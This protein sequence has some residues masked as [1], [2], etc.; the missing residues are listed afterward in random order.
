MTEQER[1][2][3]MTEAILFSSGEPVEISRIARTLGIL[4]RDVIH[5]I[6]HLQNRYAETNSALQ[7]LHLETSVQIGTKPE[8]ASII[9]TALETKR[10]QPLSNAAMEVLTIIAYN[11]PVSKN[12][13]AR[14]RGIDSSSIVNSLH[15][16][17]LLEEAGR[18]DVPGHPVAYRTTDVFLRSFGLHSLKDLPALEVPVQEGEF[19]G[20][21]SEKPEQDVTA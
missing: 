14:V 11:Q 15:D 9:R 17:G 3:A 4:E 18:I 13:V 2:S 21:I 19:T 10:M 1:L 5:I 20:E 7:I 6:E 16:K 12:F 8:F